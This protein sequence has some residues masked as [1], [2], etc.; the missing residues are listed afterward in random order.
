MEISFREGKRNRV[1]N[2]LRRG[3]RNRECKVVEGRRVGN[4]NR[5]ERRSR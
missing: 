2:G 1:R 3:E 4:E 5:E